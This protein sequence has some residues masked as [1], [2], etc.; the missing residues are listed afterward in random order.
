MK[1]SLLKNYAKL[2]AVVGGN[3]RPGQDVEIFARVR[4]VFVRRML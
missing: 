4:H 1:K 2:I 3:I